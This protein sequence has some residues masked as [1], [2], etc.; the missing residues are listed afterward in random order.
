MPI[1]A[2]AAIL[3]NTGAAD[4]PYGLQWGRSTWAGGTGDDR[5]HQTQWLTALPNSDTWTAKK[6]RNHPTLETTV[7]VLSD[8]TG[9]DLP[10]LPESAG[11]LSLTPTV[12]DGTG[13]SDTATAATA[14]I[15]ALS[16]YT[17]IY[18]DASSTATGGEVYQSDFAGTT[19]TSLTVD[20]ANTNPFAIA[21]SAF[22]GDI[23]V[24]ATGHMVASSADGA[25]H[26]VVT[27][28][29]HT[30]HIV[31]ESTVFWN[32][33][34]SD[35]NGFILRENVGVSWLTVGLDFAANQYQ[36]YN[37]A[38]NTVIAS[39][40]LSTLG[41][42]V[43]LALNTDYTIK[44]EDD[45]T[46]IS[47]WID[48]QLVS[49]DTIAPHSGNT[50]HGLGAKSLG[51]DRF[52]WKDVSFKLGSS[53]AGSNSSTDAI[54]DI[55]LLSAFINTGSLDPTLI[56]VAPG[57]YSP[58]TTIPIRGTNVVMRWGTEGTRPLFDAAGLA[59]GSS[60]ITVGNGSETQRRCTIQGIEFGDS[61]MVSSPFDGSSASIVDVAGDTITVSAAFY[62]ACSTEDPV[63]YSNITGAPI[64]GVTAEDVQYY[65]IKTGTANEVQLATSAANAGTGTQVDITALSDGAEHY[66]ILNAAKKAIGRG[67]VCIDL[68]VADCEFDADLPDYS[69]NFLSDTWSSS[70]R[71]GVLRCNLLNHTTSSY[72]YGF[73]GDL[74]VSIIDCGTGS[75]AQERPCR[76]NCSGN[77]VTLA[78]CGWQQTSY[79]GRNPVRLQSCAAGSSVYGCWFV[80][81]QM[82]FG[83]D[84]ENAIQP[85]VEQ[86]ILSGI[87]VYD[88]STPLV[89]S[90][91][92]TDQ[93]MKRVAS[94][95]SFPAGGE[96]SGVF[97]IKRDSTASAGMA[98][99]NVTV[100]AE[101]LALAEL[102]SIVLG[103]V[104]DGT[105]LDLCD[106]ENVFF[107][108]NGGTTASN[109]GVRLDINLLATAVFTNCTLPEDS[110]STGDLGRA[111]KV[112]TLDKTEAEFLAYAGETGTTFA[113]ITHDAYWFPTSLGNETIPNGVHEDF[114]GNAL[115][116]GGSA[117]AGAVSASVAA[118]TVVNRT[119][120]A[121]ATGVSTAQ[122]IS[123]QFSENMAI[124]D[125]AQV[126]ELRR[127]SDDGV[128][129]SITAGDLTINISD[130]TQVTL[131]GLSL[132]SASGAV[133]VYFPS[134][135]V[136]A[137]AT[138]VSFAGYLTSTGWPFTVGSL[139]ELTRSTSSRLL[140]SRLL[141][142][143]RRR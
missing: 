4:L 6:W 46:D 76:L 40:D 65:I 31:I 101:S 47:F 20:V 86:C 136:Q 16:G 59:P 88:G 21:F 68:C 113:D 54:A 130:R 84:A 126:I 116:P 109:T 121:N 53:G 51:N 103:R 64:G 18:L 119:P 12:K 105:N 3:T 19:G 25:G 2:T 34:E 87:D 56:H 114:Y 142:N 73:F 115:T 123:M 52:Q 17:N 137:V 95:A 1:A 77:R 111:V 127:V 94:D 135:A 132:L 50:K 35:V 48:G 11:S 55:D 67:G 5:E 10:V 28:D 112:D 100:S 91:I 134:M 96:Y 133:Y 122:T 14:T 125:T 62:A 32:T 129:D 33:T 131:T 80:G 143:K 107:T 30:T 71:V 128:I 138:G 139:S 92:L 90:C 89:V 37:R 49:T 8:F 82:S 118:P 85:R 93:G 63:L 75:T 15:A 44:V 29:F 124:N 117:K 36:V 23:T 110:S 79:S 98:V 41:T 57:T 9:Y 22:K 72:C 27:T 24:A 7:D 120:A 99:R 108:F 45:G 140:T 97:G 70:D 102:N 81:T 104:D 58:T 141:F 66:L 42:P 39:V 78:Y 74:T 43:T 83:G 69:M 61:S 106:F 38:T 26:T 60:I 13:A